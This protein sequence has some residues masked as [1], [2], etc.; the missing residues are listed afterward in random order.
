MPME[1]NWSSTVNIDH[2]SD[3]RVAVR[4]RKGREPRPAAPPLLL[5]VYQQ[6]LLQ[7]VG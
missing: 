5:L 4:G 3:D 6:P 1:D 2:S 7:P